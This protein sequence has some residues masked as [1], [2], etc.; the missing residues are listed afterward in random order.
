MH[1]LVHTHTHTHIQ[2]GSLAMYIIQFIVRNANDSLYICAA[3]MQHATRACGFRFKCKWLFAE[4]MWA[5][6]ARGAGAR[7]G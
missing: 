1:I 3:W 2:E 6:P 4:F 7:R 5:G